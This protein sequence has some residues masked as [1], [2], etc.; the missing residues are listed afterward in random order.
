VRFLLRLGGN[1]KQIGNVRVHRALSSVK[2]L[3]DGPQTNVGGDNG[4][5]TP[6]RRTVQ[7]ISRQRPD[8]CRTPQRGRGIQTR[9]IQSVCGGPRPLMVSSRVLLRY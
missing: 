9:Y 3:P 5:R 2:R 6:K 1:P 4:D 7:A 8:S